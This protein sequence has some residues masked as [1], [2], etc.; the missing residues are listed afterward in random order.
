MT[1]WLSHQCHSLA[2]YASR[3]RLALCLMDV[4]WLSGMRWRVQQ[5]NNIATL[6]VCTSVCLHVCVYVHMC[7]SACMSVCMCMYVCID[8][9]NMYTLL[10][11]IH[12]G[13]SVLVR[14][15]E[16]FIKQTAIDA[17]RPLLANNVR[18]SVVLLSVCLSVSVCPSV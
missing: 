7:L 3:P 16:E 2:G 8:L 6:C 5:I 9:C 11:P 1:D 17:V 4:A 13:L 12:N 18:R 15:L 10:C 14:E